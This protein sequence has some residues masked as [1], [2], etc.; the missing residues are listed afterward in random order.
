MLVHHS[1]TP[2]IKFAVTHLYTWM[3]RGTVRVKCLAQ[4]HDAM[5]KPGQLNP[6]TSA[7]TMRPPRFHRHDQLCLEH[8]LY[9]ASEYMK[10]QYL[11][12]RER[13]KDKNDHRSYV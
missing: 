5:L 8:D 13:C 6:E 1:V 2:S 7:L 3:E 4:E 10:D 9:I 11:N 12:C